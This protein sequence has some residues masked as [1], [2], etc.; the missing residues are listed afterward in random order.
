LLLGLATGVI[1][2]LIGIAE[3]TIIVPV[4]S[5]QSLV[6]FRYPASMA[7]P[8]SIL[9][10]MIKPV[11]KDLVCPISP[12]MAGIALPPRRKLTAMICHDQRDDDTLTKGLSVISIIP[13]R[14]PLRIG[15]LNF[16]LNKVISVE[17]SWESIIL[18]L[19]PKRSK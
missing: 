16:R 8:R 11:A 6:N 15:V 12:I 5:Y 7:P 17:A 10:K 3:G 1:S 14:A 9:P 2:N 18:N 4:L 19:N 13:E